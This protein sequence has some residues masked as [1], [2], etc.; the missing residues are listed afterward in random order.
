MTNV[1]AE[2]L[3]DDE[4]SSLVEYLTALSGGQIIQHK[5]IVDITGLTNKKIKFL[6]HK[7]LYTRHLPGY[8]VLD[9]AGKFEIVRLKPMD[10]GSIVGLRVSGCSFRFFSGLRRTIS[11]FP[12]V[13]RTP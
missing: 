1:V 2:D 4:V 9:T 7:F 11:N 13:S 10:S 3:Q 6:L 5:K 12:A 8:G